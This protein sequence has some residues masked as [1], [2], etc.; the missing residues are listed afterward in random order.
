M[1]P[2]LTNARQRTLLNR[3]EQRFERL[4]GGRATECLD[5]LKLLLSL[6]EDRMCA[7]DDG[8]RFSAADNVLIT[9]GDTIRR[10]GMTPL[11]AL[12]DFLSRRLADVIDT[13]HILPFFPWSSDDGFSVIDYRKVDANLGTWTEIEEL[14]GQFRLMFDL[15]LNH[16][17]KHSEWFRDYLMGVAPARYYFHEVE[18]FT[19]LSMVTRPRPSPL[20]HKARTRSGERWVWTTFSDDQIDLN[21]ANPDVLLEFVDILLLY[22][23]KGAR[24]VRLD[25]IAYLWKEIGTTCVHLPQTHEVVKLL[26]NVAELVAPHVLMLTETNVPH[27]ENVSYFGTGD[28]AHMVYNFS[29]PPLLLHA[30]QRGSGQY[31]TRWAQQLSDPPRGCTYLNFTASHDGIGVRP[32]EGLVPAGE[33]AALAK[34]MRQLGGFVSEKSNPDGTTSPYELNI[35]YFSAMGRPGESNPT[36][37]VQRFL[38]SQTIA[39]SLRGV[40]A[41]YLHSLLAMPNDVE[42]VERLGYPRAINRRKCDGAEI[43]AQLDDDSTTAAHVFAEYTRRLHLRREQKAFAPDAVQKVH[44]LGEAVFAV[45]RIRARARGG[46]KL[47]MLANLTDRAVS[48]DHAPLPAERCV[49]LLAPSD[50]DPVANSITLEPYQVCWLTD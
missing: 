9:Y 3:I 24:I 14:G 7:I 20:L 16:C 42:G 50:A 26:R 31:L 13:V 22:I 1:P 21:F 49:D 34:L 43:E 46:Q 32:L 27:E 45:E 11:A 8:P 29:L 47:L 18:P 38:A 10:D 4:Y 39:M 6:Y 23:A 30:L 37:Q 5:R 36:R 48:I 17:S 28:E 12:N 41:I 19:D 25:A 40:P 44:D 33:I 2:A 15:V 35:T